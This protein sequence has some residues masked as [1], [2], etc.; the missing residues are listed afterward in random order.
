[1][2]VLLVDDDVL[3]RLVMQTHL[4][5]WGHQVVTAGDGAAAWERFQVEEFPI[6]ISDW[7]MPEIDGVELIRRIRACPRP[8]YVYA[9]LVTAKSQRED[10]IAGMEAGADDFLSKPLDAEEFRVRVR[11]GERIIRLEQT[12]VEQN[13]A[14]R[15]AQSALIQTEKLAS[16]GQLAAGLAHEINNPIAF[17]TNNLAVLRR[18]MMAA[19]EILNLY[20]SAQARLAEIEPTL[21]ATTHHL[22]EE[23][24]LAF[25]QS[26]LPRLFDKTQAGLERV[27]DIVNNLRDFARLDESTFKDADLNAALDTTVEI[28]HHELKK[29][30]MHLVRCLEELPPVPCQA[31]KINQVFLNILLNAVQACPTEGT[32]ELHS[33]LLPGAQVEIV[34]RDNGSGIKP[35]HLEHI[36]DPFFTT[37][38][39]GEGT[40]LGLSVAYGIIKEHGGAIEVESQP[41]RGTTFRI[42]LPLVPPQAT[43]GQDRFGQ[44]RG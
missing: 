34:I 9:V 42:K 28:L 13:R 27:R 4:E 39:L 35:E 22:A 10:L 41:G 19:L 5:R 33:R 15:E 23:M 7:I 1:M 8:G 24:D 20:Q 12:L 30:Q 31:G 21:A 44:T 6:V 11:V 14:L 25:F 32:I 37:K 2:K 43:R 29:K 3:T 40:G 16:L 18:D 26:H 36:F 38:P 17:V